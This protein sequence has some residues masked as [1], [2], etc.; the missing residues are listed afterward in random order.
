MALDADELLG[1]IGLLEQFEEDVDK[2][3]D[4]AKPKDFPSASINWGDLGCV[5]AS[6][7]IDKNK[8][9]FFIAY[10]EELDP[11]NSEFSEWVQSKLAEKGYENVEIRCSW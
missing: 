6:V 7:E 8:Q 10:V 4:S 5:R 2:I 3:I 9:V 1:P 11:H